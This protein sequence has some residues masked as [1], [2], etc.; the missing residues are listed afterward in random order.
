MPV[1]PENPFKGRQYPGDVIP[2]AVR[3]YLRY[4]LAYEH[5]AELLAERGLAVDRSCIW[6]SR[7]SLCSRNQQTLSSA[8][9]INEQEL[10]GRRDIDTVG[11]VRKQERVGQTVSDVFSLVRLHRTSSRLVEH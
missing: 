11:E 3:W 10:P 8:S 4:P 5:V 1:T 2:L 7:A 9:E 6:R